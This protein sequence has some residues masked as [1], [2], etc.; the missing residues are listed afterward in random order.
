VTIVVE[1]FADTAY[2]APP[3][4]PRRFNRAVCSRIAGVALCSLAIALSCFLTEVSVLGRFEQNHDQQ[5]EYDNLRNE[6][7]NGIAPISG[8][9]YQ[10]VQLA[11]GAPVA[12]LNI[13]EIGLNEVVAEGTTSGVLESGPGHQRN[14]AF[15]GQAGTSI[16]MGREATY[17][18][19]FRYL[20]QLEAGDT[21]TVTTGQGT[22]TYRVLDIRYAGGAFPPPAT[23]TQGRLTLITATGGA[24]MPND[25]VR[26]DSVLISPVQPSQGG[27]VVAINPDETALSGES[28]ADTLIFFWGELLLAATAAA[29]WARSRWGRLQTWLIG[30]PVLGVLGLTLA[31]Q[32]ARLLPNL[33]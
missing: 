21:F 27:P 7:A 16:I 15:P 4:A 19:P 17:G 33:L 23:S 26:V 29:F 20:D 3:A 31:D 1:T 22:A 11:L 13:P 8:Y 30:A 32:I 28:T 10:G 5:L 9:D 12:L 6:L 2:E 25:E 18:G 14:S 24:Y